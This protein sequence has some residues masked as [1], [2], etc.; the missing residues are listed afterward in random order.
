M[1]FQ[2]RRKFCYFKETSEDTKVKDEVEE[3]VEIQ[4]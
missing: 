4:E 2:S 3:K 1:A